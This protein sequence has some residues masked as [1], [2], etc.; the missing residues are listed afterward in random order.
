MSAAAYRPV[1]AAY[2]SGSPVRLEELG[3]IIDSV[4]E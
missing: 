4:E 2:R 3:S 1:V